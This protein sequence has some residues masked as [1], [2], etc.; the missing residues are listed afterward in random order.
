MHI[1]WTIPGLDFTRK[2][3]FF[4]GISKCLGPFV[5]HGVHGLS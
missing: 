4:L 3:L 2:L 1:G 5:E